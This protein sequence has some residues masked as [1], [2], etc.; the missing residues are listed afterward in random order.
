MPPET[1]LAGHFLLGMRE[2]SPALGRQNALPDQIGKIKWP[3][4]IFG[5]KPSETA[6]ILPSEI[7]T[8]RYQAQEKKKETAQ[9]K[10]RRPFGA[11]ALIIYV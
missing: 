9:Q 5:T 2:A 11:A 3:C 8:A 6:A 4:A 1:W 7:I 10:S